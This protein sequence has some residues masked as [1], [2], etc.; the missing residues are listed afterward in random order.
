MYPFRRATPVTPVIF[1]LDTVRQV[2]ADTLNM[3]PS[4]TLILVTPDTLSLEQSDTLILV[5]LDTL[6]L[7]P[8]DSLILVSLDT[9]NLEPSDSLRKDAL[10]VFMYASD[11]IKQEITFINYVRDLKDAQVYIISSSQ[12]TGAGGEEYS[13]LL[14][15]QQEFDGMR[16][17]VSF[18]TSADDTMEQTRRKEV[19]TLKMALM[20]YVLKT[21][22]GKYI[23]IDF[24]AP[25][26]EEVTTDKWNNWVFRLSA[27]GYMN[28]EKS[29]NSNTYYGSISMRKITEQW[30]IDFGIYYGN[31]TD[32]Y[33]YEDETYK[34]NYLEKTFSALMVRSLGEHW[35]IGLSSSVSQST[36]SNYDLRILSM[37]GIEFN[38]FPYTESTRKLL[39]F[40]YSAGYFHHDYTDTTIYDQTTENLWGQSLFAIYTIIQK[41]GH[42]DI[43]LEWMNYFHDWDLN[44]LSFYTSFEFRI[45]KG[46]SVEIE[47]GASMIHD[48]INLPKGGA[49]KDEV[50]LRRK[51]LETQFSYYSQIGFT[52]TF[53]SIYNN[54]VNPRFKYGGAAVRIID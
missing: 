9:L 10:R 11:Y 29:Y 51:E 31:T 4:D 1:P 30:N 13:Y 17:T 8:S 23:N 7:E 45:A 37:P 28:A 53:G 22:L 54:V 49:S 34:Y 48:Q 38:A 35:G 27:Y 19:A 33:E 32:K 44:R 12:E 2:P 42:G 15:G 21:P 41:W 43:G 39:T 50:L 3:D 52:Y 20:R 6:N 16:D 47:G 14:I 5:S 40:N 25:I 26:E 46:F 36:Y 24:T 18:T